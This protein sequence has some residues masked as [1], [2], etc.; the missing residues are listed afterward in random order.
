MLLA[1]TNG[2]TFVSATICPQQCVL[3][4]QGLYGLMNSRCLSVMY[5][6][7]SSLRCSTF[8]CLV[9]TS[10]IALFF[11]WLLKS[12]DVKRSDEKAV[13]EANMYYFI[14]S[15]N[16]YTKSK[17]ANSKWFEPRSILLWKE[18]LLVTVTNNSSFQNHPHPDDHTR[19][20]NCRHLPA[21]S[22]FCAF[23]E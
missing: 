12:R 20:K 23:K 16:D 11:S 4:C 7:W 19:Q 21:T 17:T 3:V 5:T 8:V 13:R 2:E 10:H 6:L 9:K 22:C 18:L 15:G 1:R 14:E